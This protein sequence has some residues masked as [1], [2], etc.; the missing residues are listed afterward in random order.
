MVNR[1]TRGR[2]ELLRR[3]NNLSF[4]HHEEVAGLAEGQQD[5][6]LDWAEIGGEWSKSTYFQ[7]DLM[8]KG[9]AARY[10]TGGPHLVTGRVKRTLNHGPQVHCTPSTVQARACYDKLLSALRVV[11][12]TPARAGLLPFPAR[13]HSRI[14]F[15]QLVQ[16]VLIVETEFAVL[17]L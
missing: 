5:D 1:H 10:W 7:A 8:V 17:F 14:G 2:F 9:K 4:A 6:W 16:C 11:S 3:R 12:H 13:A 15:P